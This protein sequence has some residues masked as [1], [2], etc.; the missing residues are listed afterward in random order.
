MK[1]K[2]CQS[3][4]QLILPRAVNAPRCRT[5]SKAKRFLSK[6]EVDK[7]SGKSF[8]LR[9]KYAHMAKKK[10]LGSLSRRSL[11]ALEVVRSLVTSPQQKRAEKVCALLDSAYLSTSEVEGLPGAGANWTSESGLAFD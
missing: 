6:V 11:R 10:P 4:T 8:V 1:S 7:C 5:S 3:Y 9:I 2:Q